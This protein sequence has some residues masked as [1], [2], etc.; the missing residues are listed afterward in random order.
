[1]TG[2]GDEWGQGD[3]MRASTIQRS[4]SLASM[5]LQLKDHKVT[6]DTRAIVSACDSYTVGLSNILSELIES[7]ANAVTQPCEV[8][9]SE[10]MLARITRCNKDLETLRKQKLENGE[11]LSEEE[12]KIFV[13]GA[14]VIALFPSM[15]SMR[16]ARIAREE[17]TKSLIEFEGMN[18]K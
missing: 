18:Y 15:T 10:D 6:L 13:L 1:M 9:R 8:V 5:F 17:V 3:R 11:H 16:T 14:D 4:K 7:V 2:M 12:E